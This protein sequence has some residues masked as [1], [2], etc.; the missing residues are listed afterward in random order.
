MLED[1][2]PGG[3]RITVAGDRGYDTDG[4]VAACR[5][6]NITPHAEQNTRGRSSRID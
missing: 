3:T 4:F 1:N 5:M 2:L 6:R